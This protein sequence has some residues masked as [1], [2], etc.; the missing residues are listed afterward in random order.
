MYK[1]LFRPGEYILKSKP[2]KLTSFF[3]PKHSQL[4]NE[5]KKKIKE[6]SDEEKISKIKEELNKI[7]EELEIKKTELES[8][9]LESEELKLKTQEEIKNLL[10]DAEKQANDIKEIAR[11]NGFDEGFEKGY[12]DGLAKAKSEVEQKFS[13]LI[14][15]LQSIVNSALNE[16][17]KIINSAEDDIIELSTAIAK[18]IINS[19]IKTDKTLIINLVKEAIKKLEDKEKIT[20]YT[21]P[22]DLEL[23]KSHREEFKELVDTIDTLHIIPDELLEPGEC[24]LESKSEIIDTDINYQL[25]EIK[26]KLHS[27]E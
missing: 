11:K 18:K 10:T 20:I 8:I 19:E 3:L 4:L 22:S 23:I 1:N 24:R 15:N 25:G 26:K 7:N 2:Y 12:Y 16:K 6:E 27:K 21:H 5:L 13:S 9:K 14:N 17:N